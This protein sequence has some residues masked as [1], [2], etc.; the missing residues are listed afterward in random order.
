MTESY[1]SIDGSYEKAE[2][3]EALPISSDEVSSQLPSAVIVEYAGQKIAIDVSYA[4][5]VDDVK[6]TILTVFELGSSTRIFVK[7]KAD[8]AIVVP[9][10][11]LP[12]GE[13]SLEVVDGEFLKAVKKVRDVHFPAFHKEVTEKHLPLVVSH[14]KVG[15]QKVGETLSTF[16]QKAGEGLAVT[17]THINRGLT[18]ASTHVGNAVATAGIHTQGQLRR[19]TNIA[20]QHSTVNSH[21]WTAQFWMFL[22]KCAPG[23]ISFVTGIPADELLQIDGPAGNNVEVPVSRPADA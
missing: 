19:M 21:T 18:V 1:P 17:G 13:Y 4:V 7:R 15:A 20:T 9:G 22:V 23:P 14:G 5:S 16:Q 3:P 8:G 11:K 12:P 10:P 2:A 6:H